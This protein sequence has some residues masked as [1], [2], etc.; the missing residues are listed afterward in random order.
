MFFKYGKKRYEVD[1]EKT[2]ASA[3]TA[4]DFEPG[5]TKDG[6]L[7]KDAEITK[8]FADCE[9]VILSYDLERHVVE[10]CLLCD[11]YEVIPADATENELN[12]LHDFF[13]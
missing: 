8:D 10:V 11:E 9:A 2:L 1:V 7:I 6:V 12:M 5:L 13:E 3:V 4:E